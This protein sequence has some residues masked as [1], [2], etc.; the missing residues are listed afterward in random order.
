VVD[1]LDKAIMKMKKGEV[2]EISIASKY[3]FAEETKRDLATV[4]AGA[5]VVYIVELVELVNPKGDHDLSVQEKLDKAKQKKEQGN[6]AYKEGKF[7]RAV[8][9]YEQALKPIEFDSNF[10]QDL[11]IQSKEMKKTIWLNIAA[12][13]LKLD[14]Y[15]KAVANCSKV[16]DIDPNNVK[17]LFRRSQGYMYR[18]DFIEA[19]SD[20]KKAH[21]LEPANR[22]VIAQYKKL[23]QVMK[24]W[25][26]K[27]A[28]LYSN[29]FKKM[30]GKS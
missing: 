29:I 3:A 10:D 27:D 19:E 18:S 5:D 30:A 7:I 1:G 26:K 6:K 25:D 9:K 28:A 13:A 15:N 4:P 23:K 2:A 8:S 12:V 21:D 16:L 17:A 11:K 14:E 24:Q 20:I 22:D